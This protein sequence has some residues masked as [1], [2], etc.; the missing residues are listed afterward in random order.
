MEKAK[1]IPTTKEREIQKELD[2]AERRIRDELDEKVK[3]KEK[4]ALNYFTA[5][6]YD[7]KMEREQAAAEK[8]N[9]RSLSALLQ[10]L[11]KLGKKDMKKL[12]AEICT[13]LQQIVDSVDA[14]EERKLALFNFDE[15]APENKDL[16]EAMKAL[17]MDKKRFAAFAFSSDEEHSETLMNV[18]SGKIDREEMR[19]RKDELEKIRSDS[20]DEAR[21]AILAA[22]EGDRK[23]FLKRLCIGIRNACKHYASKKVSHEDAM[24][25]SENV[26]EM[27]F[28]E[29]DNEKE[30]LDNGL[31]KEQL[32]CA[33]KIAQAHISIRTALTQ[34]KVLRELQGG[35]ANLSDEAKE[36]IRASIKSMDSFMNARSDYA[37]VWD[38][39]QKVKQQEAVSM[40]IRG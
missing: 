16:V 9:I 23:R 32:E 8:Q 24:E 34:M 39:P 2:R 4:E 33:R 22:K 3:E 13:V 37:I 10:A 30:L 38:E 7:K 40:S 18:I 29:K 26:E 6:Y 11:D 35:G 21:D 15:N 25:W 17:N 19:K 31:S 1:K 28:I 5:A 20:F 27:L 14:M 12:P 36:Q